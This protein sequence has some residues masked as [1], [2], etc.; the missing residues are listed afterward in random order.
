MIIFRQAANDH[1]LNSGKSMKYKMDLLIKKYFRTIIRML[2]YKHAIFACF[3]SSCKS[4]L[5]LSGC[6]EVGIEKMRSIF[7]QRIKSSGVARTKP[8]GLRQN[9]FLFSYSFFA[10][11]KK[12]QKKTPE[13]DNAAFSGGYPDAAVVLL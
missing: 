10:C 7:F 6:D 9:I 12:K 11:P 4:R 2:H 8:A 13:N 5:F 1:R 3:T